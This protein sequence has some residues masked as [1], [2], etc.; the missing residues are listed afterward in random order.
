MENTNKQVEKEAV[1]GIL[2]VL[3]HEK[4]Y[5][6]MDALLILSGYC[7]ATWS[8][9]QG[10]YLA[11][12]VGFRQLIIGAFFG[13]L[14]ML[15]IYQ[16]P[17]ILSVRYGIDIWIWLRSVFGVKGVKAMTVVIILINFP[18]YA[19]CCDLFASSMGS[20]ASLFGIA[21]PPGSRVFLGLFC[22]LAGTYIAHRGI[23]TITWT[24]RILVPAL[25]AV[26][27]I[28]VL[29]AFMNVPADV[30]W[31]YTP[32]DTG[33]GDS[34]I[35]YI[36][37]I[38]A[39]FAFVITLVGGMA[40]IPRL[41]RSEK[42]GYFAG[43]FGQGLAG[44][45]FVV[46]G[47]VMAIATEYVTGTMIDDPTMMLAVL[48]VPVLSLCSL[49]LVAFANIGTQAV[50]SYIYGV[51]LKSTFKKANYQLLITV[52]GLYV[53]ILCIWG[54]IVTY[55]GAF[56]TLSACIYAPLAA[57]LFVDF[58]FVRRQRIA[59]RSAYEMKGYDSYVYTRGYNLIGFFCLAA[60][61]LISLLI[62]NPVSGTI[63][64]SFLFHLTPTGCSFLATGLLYGLLCVMPP[65][66]RYV[67][68]DLKEIPDT[69]PFDR[70]R[71]PPKQNLLAMPFIW[72]A[73]FLITRKGRLKIEKHGMKHIKP[74]YL[75]LGTHQSF[76]DFF[77]TPLALFPRRANYVSE[78][79]GFENYGEWLYR[80]SGCLGTRKFIDDQ[81]LIRNIMR[82]MKR[83]GILV[84]YPEA[85]YANVGTS[86]KLP[87]SVAKL[88]KL[89]RVPVVVLNMKGNYLQSPIWNLDIRKE[90]RL[91][92]SLTCA[93]TPQELKTASVEEIYDRISA[94]LSYD[95]YAWQR[96]EN[97]AITYSKRAE[98]LHMPLYQCQSCQREGTMG[99]SKTRLFCKACGAGWKM[100]EYGDLISESADGEAIH[101]PDWYEWQ[102]QNVEMELREGRY[103]LD[104]QVRI[105]ALPNAVNFIDCGEG[106]LL[107]NREGFVLTFRDGTDH[108]EKTLQFPPKSMT[109]IHTEYDYRGKGQCITLS[110]PDNTYFLFPVKDAKGF[111]ATKIQFA[112]EYLYD[113]P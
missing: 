94:L 89:L 62:Y 14:L 97:I 74:P 72:L 1:F 53:A 8:Y 86:S 15:A 6:F 24:T 87:I 2:P 41:A 3:A 78:L 56:L 110:V 55:F 20:L 13:A 22:V 83:K 45:F 70:Y 109:S 85:R 48:S 91:H 80:Q 50:G 57:L 103:C 30:I 16:L 76:N 29:V 61:V 67:H 58:F 113:S 99:S 11:T 33:Y 35:P 66:R 4:K 12:L 42:S 69:K 84:L 60:G 28:V 95:E 38:E 105:E 106:H 82:V 88:A 19:V 49:L 18:W 98:G 104:V 77:V 96:Q 63:H 43:V 111:Y 51:M 107:H 23:G 7:I 27:V 73:S 81:G 32:K 34:L 102:R 71:V 46:V 36:L 10:S 101:I 9:T 17:V 40:E 64:N 92:A 59:L 25:L 75:V 100:D 68:R 52:L 65:F 93:F 37:S 21:L 39:N 47:A 31:N 54:K 112:T 44:S 26:G 5:K 79:E 108:R 90:A